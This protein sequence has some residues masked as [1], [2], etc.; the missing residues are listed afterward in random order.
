MRH[1]T[2]LPSHYLPVATTTTTHTELTSPWKPNPRARP[3]PPSSHLFFWPHRAPRQT[4]ARR[5]WPYHA[6]T[7]GTRHRLDRRAYAPHGRGS[8]RRNSRRLMPA[9][10]PRAYPPLRLRRRHMWPWLRGG[11]EG[12]WPKRNASRREAMRRPRRPW[13]MPV[14]R[15]VAAAPRSGNT[16]RGRGVE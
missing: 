7:A 2:S 1:R 11:G 8:G 16:G 3:P 13:W 9:P 5:A 15:L 4:S 6:V 10:R 14:R 12:A